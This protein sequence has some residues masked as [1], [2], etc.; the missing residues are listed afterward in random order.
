MLCSWVTDHLTSIATLLDHPNLREFSI[1]RIPHPA[2]HSVPPSEHETL[3]LSDLMTPKALPPALGSKLLLRVGQL[4]SL[5]VDFYVF[6]SIEQVQAL[7]EAAIN[8]EHFQLLVD[9]SLSCHQCVAPD[10]E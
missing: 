6:K 5:T 1:E 10:A 3:P 2:T 7:A 9:V 4:Q 8:L